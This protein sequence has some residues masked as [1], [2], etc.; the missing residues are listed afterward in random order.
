MQ[1]EEDAH[2]SRFT[3]RNLVVEI[4]GHQVPSCILH[5]QRDCH[6]QQAPRSAA[7]P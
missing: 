7:S 3:T 6:L 2:S 4:H 5:E 1:H